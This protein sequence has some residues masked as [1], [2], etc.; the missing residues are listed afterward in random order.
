MKHSKDG[1][2]R[3]FAFVGFRDESCAET[4]IK[5][6]SGS[7]FGRNKVII[8]A[9]DALAVPIKDKLTNKSKTKDQFSAQNVEKDK[10]HEKVNP[11]DEMKS[12]PKFKQFLDLQRNV[13]SSVDGE[14]KK[15]KYIWM[16]DVDVEDNSH[17]QSGEHMASS[18]IEP[19]D[20]ETSQG[21]N[22]SSAKKKRKEPAP[23]KLANTIKVYNLPFKCTKSQIREFFEPLKPLRIK[24]LPV[25]GFAYVSFKDEDDCKSASMKHKSFL[26]GKQVSI[27]TLRKD[28][29][30]GPSITQESKSKEKKYHEIRE[31]VE[32]TGRLYVR[33][34]SY[35]CTSED[36]E[37]LFSKFGKLTEVYLPLDPALKKHKGFA[38]VTFV[39]PEHAVAA[40]KELDKKVFQGRLIHILPGE[41]KPD[42]LNHLNNLSSYRARKEEELKKQAKKSAT[43]NTLFL[44]A[45][46]AAE[47]IAEKF[48]VT[49]ANLIADAQASDSIAVRMALGE[50]QIVNETRKFLID[51]GI[52]L[53]SFDDDDEDKVDESGDVDP[54][55]RRINKKK[56]KAR[57]KTVILVKNLPA[58]IECEVIQRLF[59]RFG[60]VT[61]VILPPH[62][63][64]AIVEMQ[65]ETEAKK[66]FDKLLN[67]K[68]NHVPIYLEWA[69]IN[70]FGKSSK[71]ERKSSNNEETSSNS[72]NES[73]GKRK[74]SET[75][76]NANEVHCEGKEVTKFKRNKSLAESSKA[77]PGYSNSK[78]IVRNVPFEANSQEVKDLFR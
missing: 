19:S 67:Y 71:R 30:E 7:Y 47:I 50:S 52:N 66:A 4:T 53:D 42:H 46:A 14:K 22:S 49:K 18:T 21:E 54:A 8:E 77:P 38:F 12:D 74:F 25:R 24:T 65:E 10:K 32:D 6:H 31:S 76:E 60:T 69:P 2:F 16:D 37:D 57:S 75:I 72:V 68:V 23:H 55:V 29:C 78:I 73:S 1:K 62:G 15:Q 27:S 41:S 70:V 26:A 11:F 44:G 13:S 63:V 58:K 61:R 5:L 35:A 45:N 43:W 59:S 51:N 40:M 48:N 3:G 20:E 28:E 56:N 33:N 17:P 64:T 9:Y 36:L 39:F 34:L